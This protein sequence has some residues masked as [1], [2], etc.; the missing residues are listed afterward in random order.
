MKQVILIHWWGVFHDN[1]TF[2]E[3]LKN[4]EYDPF[5]KKKK[6]MKDWLTEQH[7][8]KFEYIQPSMPNKQMASYKA[9]KIWFEKIFPYLN[10]NDTIL[11]WH[12]LWWIFLLKYLSENKFPKKIKQLHLISSVIDETN[13]PKEEKFLWD[14]IFDHQDIKNITPQVDQIF[15][16]HSK[17]DLVVPYSHSVRLNKFLPQAKFIS[18]ENMG[19]LNQEEFPELLENI[20][21]Q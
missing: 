10:D 12:S 3:A 15:I 5:E 19:H 6:W 2:C 20:S 21:V 17:D 1:D 14:F 16:Y 9:R 11:V 13:M 7:K 4:R 8:E 18:F